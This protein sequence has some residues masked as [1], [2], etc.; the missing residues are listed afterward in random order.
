MYV[1]IK[2]Y[3]WSRKLYKRNWIGA[4]IGKLVWRLNRVIFSCEIDPSADIALS[5]QTPHN[6]LGCVIGSDV[7]IGE[8][9]KIL[10][11]V[12]IGGRKGMA[13]MPVIGKNVT[14]GAGAVILGGITIGDGAKIGA[15][16][17]V[18]KDIPANATAVGV[19]AQIIQRSQN[20]EK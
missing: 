15:N 17:V 19:P 2:L 1:P 6:L 8:N 20:N 4:G 10:H 18:L 12:T 16:S 13:E 14:I 9:T 3:S 7:I 11:N 5:V